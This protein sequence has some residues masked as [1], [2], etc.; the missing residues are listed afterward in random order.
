MFPLTFIAVSFGSSN[1]WHSSANNVLRDSGPGG[2]GEFLSNKNW[3]SSLKE[4][5]PSFLYQNVEQLPQQIVVTGDYLATNSTVTFF[6][7]C[8]SSLVP[9]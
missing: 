9:L 7:F 3:Q 5:K 6:A 2:E 4:T 1:K 8:L